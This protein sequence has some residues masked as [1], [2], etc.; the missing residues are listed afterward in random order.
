MYAVLLHGAAVWAARKKRNVHSG[1]RHLGPYVGS[2][3][4][5]AGDGEFHPRSPASAAATLR[6]CTLPVAVRGIVSTR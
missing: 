6:R 4:A 2:N 5:G 1:V 3:G